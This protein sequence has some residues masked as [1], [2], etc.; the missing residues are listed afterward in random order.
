M[1]KTDSILLEVWK[2]PRP[3]MSVRQ[4]KNL[5]EKGIL[6]SVRKKFSYKKIFKK[7]LKKIK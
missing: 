1:F 3:D 7:N 2:R 4:E 6:V 5:H